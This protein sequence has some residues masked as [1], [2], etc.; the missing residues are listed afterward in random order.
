MPYMLMVEDMNWFEC[1]NANPSEIMQMVQIVHGIKFLVLV[2]SQT[3]P[4]DN[5]Q[6]Y[7]IGSVA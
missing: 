3:Y 1:T 5:V 7:D 2:L 6:K 4:K